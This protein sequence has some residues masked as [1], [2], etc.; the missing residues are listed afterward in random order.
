MITRC[1]LLIVGLLAVC[2]GEA[3]AAQA[4]FRDIIWPRLDRKSG[5][6]E[7]ELR[8]R[9]AEPTIANNQYRCTY[10]ELVMYKLL[11]EDGRW[12]TRRDMYLRADSGIYVHG[13]E[14]SSAK[15]KG[16]VVTELYG[17]EVTKLTT[18]DATVK[19]TWDEKT[20]TRSRII[21][22][23]SKVVMASKSR[24]MMGE[25]A[26]VVQVTT[27]DGAGDKSTVTVHRDITM[28]MRGAGTSDTLPSVPG[29][30]GAKPE[31]AGPVTITCLGPLQF[32]RIANIVLF[33]NQV[34]L[35]RSGTTLHCDDL[36]LTFE[37]PE[38]PKR[39]TKE[40]KEAR[41]KEK[42]EK[43]RERI[44]KGLPKESE[45]KK[46]GDE[47][48]DAGAKLQSMVAQGNVAVI[49]KDQ[50]F[51]GER[52]AWTPKDS[53]GILTGRPAKMTAPGSK[54]HADKIQFNQT[55]QSVNYVG[56]AVVEIELKP[57]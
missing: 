15:L 39:L 21:S 52:F 42:Q 10:P 25:G 30:G 38:R 19:A 43:E 49:G 46:T 2:G 41:K 50:R 17:Q 37:Q 29:T 6:V 47:K 54:A 12:R 20:E 7:W 36:T 3:G 18:S 31:T 34:A 33:R 8:A 40:Q 45:P 51:S 53:V 16:R 11:K 27:K 13:R 56:N 35:E 28:E 44:K 9:T 4:F 26:T 57:E 55:T 32:D 23:R 14:R 1:S 5:I 24:E 48:K 22:T